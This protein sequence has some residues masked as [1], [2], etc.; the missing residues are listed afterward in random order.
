MASPSS[1]KASQLPRL[2][3][4]PA[5]SSPEDET[6]EYLQDSFAALLKTKDKASCI[7]LLDDHPD[8]LT[9]PGSAFEWLKS[10][11]T[12]GLI[13]TEIIDI[14]F[15]DAE[16]QTDFAA[17]VKA[18]DKASCIKS[19]GENIN[20]LTRSGSPFEWLK[21]PLAIGLTPTEI[22]VVLLE[23][24]EQSPWICYTLIPPV[25]NDTDGIHYRPDYVQPVPP[26]RSDDPASGISK[27]E[28]NRRITELC[29]LG[30]IIPTPNDR[31]LWTK[32]ATVQS[33]YRSAT[34]SYGSNIQSWVTSRWIR[35]VLDQCL[36]AL[37]RLIKLFRRLQ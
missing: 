1:E 9:W 36:D 24:S 10:L 23:E 6:S 4:R 32:N 20:S 31:A 12:N 33:R 30:G 28:V 18:K 14:L 27:V 19:L 34:I 37:D 13:T 2:E 26:H 35:K 16:L 29:G 11:M 17:S 15:E 21:D 7:A 3:S 5:Q 22:V 25:G 8:S